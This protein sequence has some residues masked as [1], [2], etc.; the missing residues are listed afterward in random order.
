M[1]YRES[2][3]SALRMDHTNIINIEMYL[4]AKIILQYDHLMSH[5]SFN[6]PVSQ[7]L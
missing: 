7:L 3:A 4:K 6:R 2:A 5:L 1:G